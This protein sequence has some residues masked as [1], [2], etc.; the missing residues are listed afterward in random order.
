M[1]SGLFSKAM[2]GSSGLAACGWDCRRQG[3]NTRSSLRMVVGTKMVQKEEL[4][5]HHRHLVKE[6]GLLAGEGNPQL[7][8]KVG[9]SKLLLATLWTS[10]GVVELVTLGLSGGMIS[11]PVME[12]TLDQG[13]PSGSGGRDKDLTIVLLRPCHSSVGRTEL[14]PL[15]QTMKAPLPHNPR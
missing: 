10:K 11:P 15:C 1:S 2:Y 5:S 13:V 9:Y 14:L 3:R 4:N 6:A 7:S 8:A 12:V